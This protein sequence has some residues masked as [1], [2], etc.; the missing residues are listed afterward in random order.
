MPGARLSLQ[1]AKKLLLMI[2]AR[3][4]GMGGGREE[5]QIP[6]HPPVARARAEL[7]SNWQPEPGLEP[8]C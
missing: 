5:G 1:E 7:L 8:G 3:E 4:C 2:S 6:T